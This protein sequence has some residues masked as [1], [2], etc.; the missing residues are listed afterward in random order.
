M[1]IKSKNLTFDYC[2]KLLNFLIFSWS[3]KF[4]SQSIWCSRR[5]RSKLQLWVQRC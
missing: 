1:K 5:W 4:D 3:S 2:L